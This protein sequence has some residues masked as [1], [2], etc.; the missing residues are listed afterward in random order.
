MSAQEVKSCCVHKLPSYD[1]NRF[2]FTSKELAELHDDTAVRAN[3][4]QLW[5][6]LKAI[7][8]RKP[9]VFGSWSG[10]IIIIFDRARSF[11]PTMSVFMKF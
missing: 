9:H 2:R 5:N 4:E 1:N 6:L 8:K 11:A 10:F 7:L 3:H